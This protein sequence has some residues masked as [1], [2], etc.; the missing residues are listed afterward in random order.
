M[1]SKAIR[2]EPATIYRRD[3]QPPSYYIESIYLTF[4]LQPERTQVTSTTKFYR[5]TNYNR[6]IDSLY[7]DG[8]NLHLVKVEMDGS[9][10]SE[11][12]FSQ[13]DSG[14]TLYNPPPEFTLQITTEINPQQNK[15]L[16][17]LYRS[18]GNY[19]TQCEAEGF[20][21]I[22]YY[23]DRPDVLARFTTRIEADK[24]ECPVLLANGNRIEAGELVSGKHYAIW[25]DPFPKPSY[26]F[27][28][29]AGRLVEVQ[30]SFTTKSGRLV[31]LK[32]FIEP[33]NRDKCAHAM[34]SLKKAMRWDEQTYGLE[35]DLDTYMIVAVDDFNMGAMENKGLNIFNSKYVL[36]SPQTATDQ[37]YMGIE[38]V[39]GH[40]YFHNWTGNR[41]TCRDWFQLSLKEGLTVFRDQEFSADF[42]SR[43]V[44][45]IEDVKILRNSQFRED[46]GPMAH[47]VRPESY[48]EINNFYTLTVYNKGAEVVRMLHR[49]IGAEAFR[50]GMDLYFER[51][52][53]M[54]V[55]CDDFVNAMAEA[56]STDLRQFKLWYG[57]AGTPL[58]EVVERWDSKQ[59][60][61]TLEINQSCPPTPGQENKKSFHIPILVSLLDADKIKNNKERK[62]RD[63]KQHL[64]ELKKKKETFEFNGFTAKPIISFLR[65]FTAP[66]KVNSFQDKKE[67]AFLMAYDSDAFN[68]WDAAFKLSTAA[69]LKVIEC[70]EQS[71]QPIVED[72][73]LKAF[74]ASLNT[75]GDLALTGLA[76]TLPDDF[77]ISQN[78]EKI[79][80]EVIYQAILF[81]RQELA[82]RLHDQ[83]TRIYQECNTTG[84][85]FS[86]SENIARRKLKNCCL[87]YLLT[88]GV[89]TKNDIEIALEQYQKSTNMTDVI[90][91]L[92]SLSHLDS[93]AKEKAYTD[94]YQR[95]QNEPLVVDKWLTLQA[96]SSHPTVLSK[97]KELLTHQAF[98]LENPN[99][100]RS[101]IGA[102]CGM[103]H[104]RFHNKSGAGYRFL[105]EQVDKL[106]QINPQIAARLISP[107]IS[108]KKYTQK[109][110]V[111]MEEQLRFLAQKKNLS[112]DVYEIVKKCLDN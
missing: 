57:Q 9:I 35:Y 99:K 60:K 7:L 3:Y 38:G 19:C 85:H 109:L 58:L 67:L 111:Q 69:I 103:N 77:S 110:M 48:V 16:S 66:V 104:Y 33:Q 25:E 93:T 53:G 73:Y 52:D 78:L 54:A 15:T 79:D 106:D 98:S 49:I 56:A 74:S 68:R 30:D 65:E 89:E 92:A 6:N 44:K 32:I 2:T 26:L 46:A 43:A 84:S 55:T 24:D 62:N 17:G 29:V 1:A 50:R 28:L 72:D 34:S 81:V 41:V 22:T 11:N 45:R 31:A 63:E 20:R 10:L 8:E 21:R 105:I 88:P 5:N 4:Q 76:L 80:P 112:A 37:D 71:Q 82:R 51:Y 70:I 90:A 83:F 18:S 47:P 107:L 94:F 13:D 36:A 40:E 42:N 75:E 23:L 39:I 96:T 101:L 97:V 102:F 27:A 91:A 87:N 14:M 108:Y 100:V 59:G 86:D 12:E 95:W 61:Y 64:L